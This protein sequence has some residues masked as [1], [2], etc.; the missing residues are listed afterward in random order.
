MKSIAP[1]LIIMTLLSYPCSGE[2][3]GNRLHFKTNGY[4]IDALETT[5]DSPVYQT[6]LMH[7]PATDGFSPNVNIQI[8]IFDGSLEKYGEES[9]KSINAAGFTI[10]SE[11]KQPGSM[12]WEYSGKMQDY[13]L[14]WYAKAIKRDNKIYLATATA[15]DSQWPA[16]EKQLKQ[17][18][19]SLKLD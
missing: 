15:L 7:L 13:Q 16:V 17:C 9:E 14:R 5:T 19:D 12:T 4:S 18:V 3:T 6:L 1:F 8:Q 10:V 11:N 2:S